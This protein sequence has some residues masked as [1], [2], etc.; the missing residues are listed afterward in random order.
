[1]IES[2]KNKIHMIGIGGIGMSALGFILRDMGYELSGSD[3]EENSIT[4]K[5]KKRGVKFFVGHDK[6]YIGG[7]NLIVYSSSIR[8]DNPEIM[9]AKK[10][11][12]SVIPRIKLLDM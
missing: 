2:I 12:I 11:G 6:S 8:M 9:E 10:K 1:M 3:K 5:L 4:E 7:S